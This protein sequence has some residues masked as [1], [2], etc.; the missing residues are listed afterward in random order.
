MSI[1]EVFDMYDMITLT[2]GTNTITVYH[3]LKVVHKTRLSQ[4]GGCTMA[5]VKNL[6]KKLVGTISD[7]GKVY[8][9]IIKGC[10]T[11]ITANPDGTLNIKQSRLIDQAA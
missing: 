3:T 9:I 4:K 10:V 6:N 7:D 1:I 11:T 2:E 8:T 5:E